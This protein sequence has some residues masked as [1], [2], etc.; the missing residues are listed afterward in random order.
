MN[1]IQKQIIFIK[2]KYTKNKKC[3]T[4]NFKNISKNRINERKVKHFSQVQNLQCQ[5]VPV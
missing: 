3:K 1:K 2:L 5:Q 4:E